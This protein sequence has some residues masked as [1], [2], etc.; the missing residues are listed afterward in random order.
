MRDGEHLSAVP[1]I[2]W[3]ETDQGAFAA[4]GK[5]IALQDEPRYRDLK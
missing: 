1:D 5:L 2:P 3:Q 4:L